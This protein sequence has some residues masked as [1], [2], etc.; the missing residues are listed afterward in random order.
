MPTDWLPCP[1]KMNAR[2]WVLLWRGL[3]GAGGAMRKTG[4]AN[5]ASLAA[6]MVWGELFRC[7]FG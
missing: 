6:G 3:V 5:N 2:M 7:A 4:T 1:G